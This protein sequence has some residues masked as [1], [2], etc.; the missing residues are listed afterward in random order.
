M[1]LLSQRSAFREMLAQHL[2][3]HACN[4]GKSAIHSPLYEPGSAVICNLAE[5]KEYMAALPSRQ[6]M[7]PCCEVHALAP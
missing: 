2:G 6:S 1:A 5:S 4:T 3:C 7:G